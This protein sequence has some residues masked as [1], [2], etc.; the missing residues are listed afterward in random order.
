MPVM[1]FNLRSVPE[2]EA[3]EIRA[4]LSK[5]NIDYYET[6]AGRWG[7]SVEAIWLKDESLLDTS[8]QLIQGYQQQRSQRIR[9]E[10]K[11]LKQQG[12]LESFWQR[13]INRP[14]QTI[15]YIAIIL[16]IIYLVTMPFV[17]LALK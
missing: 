15:S 6:P 4:L 17:K 13:I 14:V 8:K 3:E 1:L 16:T 9:Q 11:E 12:K 2:D 5:N 7:I 10:F